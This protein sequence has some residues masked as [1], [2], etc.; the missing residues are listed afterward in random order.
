MFLGEYIM[1]VTII[2]ILFAHFLADFLFQNS[3]MAKNKSSNN[4]PLS[5]HIL[6]YSGILLIPSF[7]IFDNPVNAWYFTIINAFLHYCVDYWTS[8]L[9]SYC[10]KNNYMGTNYLPNI[11]FWTVIGFDQFL[12][13]SM[14]I[15]TLFYFMNWS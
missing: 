4:F 6:V 7:F 11:S 8:K 9:S 13:S 15:S 10:Y 12:H 1:L 5:A 2:I 3:W 14:L